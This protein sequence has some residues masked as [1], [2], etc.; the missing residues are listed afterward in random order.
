MSAPL[1]LRRPW[2]N[3]ISHHL[4][5]SVTAACA[6]VLVLMFGV[7]VAL[8][9]RNGLPV[10]S[11]EFLSDAPRN[12]MTE[13][14]ILPAIV[15]TVALTMLMTVMTVPAGVLT[16]IYLCEYSPRGSRLA[17]LVRLCVRN[18]A[19]VPSIVFGLFG[20]GFFV[21]TLGHGVDSI[22]YRG[23]VTYGKPCMIWA[24]ATLAIL[25]LPRRGGGDGRGVAGGAA[26]D[27]VTP[28]WRSARRSCRRSFASSYRMRSRA[29]S[30]ARFWPWG[31]EQGRWRRFSSRELRTTF[32]ICHRT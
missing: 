26:R 30:L 8:V 11:W 3:G 2:M 5:T 16:A 20:V 15:G 14:G 10:L 1:H 27:G 22:A 23:H 25:T 19:G 9:I 32:Q 17:S 31:A 24:A 13:G 6:A 21:S 18:L 7:L 29:S 28:A 4:T 12:G